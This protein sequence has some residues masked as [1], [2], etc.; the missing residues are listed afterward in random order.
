VTEDAP[1]R[2]LAVALHDVSRRLGRA[3]EA[4][5]GLARLPPTE[6]EVLR[7]VGDRPGARVSEVAAGLAAQPSN[8]STAV[9]ALVGRGLLVREADPA[10][11]RAVRLRL[12]ARA[13]RDREAIEIAWGR[14]VAGVLD[15]LSAGDRATLTAATPALR[16]LA[17]GLARRSR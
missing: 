5:A 15:E 10:D 1:L 3:G 12:S 6:L 2:T 8:V 11:R 7:L 16:A 9:R 13:E 17:D 14:M 4:A